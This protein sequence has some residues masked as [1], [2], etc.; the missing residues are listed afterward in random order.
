MWKSNLQA[1]ILIYKLNSL[2]RR[3][4]E[5]VDGD[6][7]LQYAPLWA[8][9]AI[10]ACGFNMFHFKYILII[11]SISFASKIKIRPISQL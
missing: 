6:N 2:A 4:A 10:K 11:F 3:A 5:Q 7:I 1:P 9:L 8:Y